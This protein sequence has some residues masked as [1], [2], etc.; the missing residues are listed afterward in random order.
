MAQAIEYQKLM[1]EI[2]YIN[3]PR[4]KEPT[5]VTPCLHERR[6]RGTDST[7][8]TKTCVSAQSPR[9]G[10]KVGLPAQRRE[11]YLEI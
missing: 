8:R 6:P 10:A 3:L 4:P 5:P 9:C 7:V 1:T 11:D 2:V